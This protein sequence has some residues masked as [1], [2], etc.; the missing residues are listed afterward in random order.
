MGALP[1]LSTG[2]RDGGSCTIGAGSAGAGSPGGEEGRWFLSPPP[3]KLN[4]ASPERSGVARLPKQT[5]QSSSSVW[6]Q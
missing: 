1:F 4:C 2:H 6:V 5:R 3:S